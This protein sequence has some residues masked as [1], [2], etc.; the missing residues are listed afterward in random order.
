MKSRLAILS[1][2]FLLV[3][4]AP[5]MIAP[6][7]MAEYSYTDWIVTGD[8]VRENETITAYK[9]ITVKSG[10]SLTLRNV[11]LTFDSPTDEGCGIIAEPGS[12]LAIY[13]STLSRP[14]YSEL[15]GFYIY[16]DSASFVMKDSVLDGA[17]H[18]SKLIQKEWVCTERTAALTLDHVQGVVIEG[19]VMKHIPFDVMALYDVSDSTIANNTI[20]PLHR[21]LGGNPSF[22]TMWDSQNN[23]ITDNYITGVSSAISMQTHSTGNYV[24]GNKITTR[25]A[26]RLNYGIMLGGDSN[27]NTLADNEILDSPGGGN[28]IVIYTRSNV[29]KNNTIRD[30]KWGILLAAGAD[31]NIVANNNLSK[32]YHEDAIMVYRSNGSYI[33]NNNIFSSI[34]GISVSRFSQD[35]IIQANTISNCRQGILV[36]LSSDNNLIVNNEVSKNKVGIMVYKSSGNKIYD[37]SFIGNSQQGYNDGENTWSVNNRGNHWSDYKGEGDTAYNIAPTGIDEHPLTESVPIVIAPE[38]EPATATFREIFNPPSQVINGEVK[39]ENTEILMENSYRIPEGGTLILENVTLRSYKEA[40]LIYK[41]EVEGGTLIISNSIIIAPE[42]GIAP[43][44]IHARRDS[45]LVIQDSE[46]YHVDSGMRDPGPSGGGIVIDCEG[47]IVE[48]NYITDSRVGVRLGSR[49]GSAHIVN[50]IFEDCMM[51]TWSSTLGG[52][53]LIEG[54][55]VRDLVPAEKL[56]SE[57]E[58]VSIMLFHMLLYWLRD[59]RVIAGL[60]VIGIGVVALVWFLIKRRRRRKAVAAGT[61]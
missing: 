52:D 21:V 17:S 19:N 61:D 2:C 59:P 51:P 24:A 48:G 45:T 54:N 23:T 60:I 30:F 6:A 33:I 18:F 42:T 20:T 34:R 57:S 32:I 43:I 31:D 46:F 28:A 40:A 29:I 55:T 37:N 49:S 39:Y 8:E 27:N 38:P 16:V 13:N 4:L 22:L 1:V 44:T 3:M 11:T 36:A 14:Q 25:N 35:N 58:L 10:A 7:A 15:G 56:N 47:A 41:I 5:V 26:E 12:S 53:F 9:M 50:N